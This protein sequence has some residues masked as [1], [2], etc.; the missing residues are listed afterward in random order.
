LLL[1][2][3]SSSAWQSEG[4]VNP[5]RSWLATQA[6]TKNTIR[7]ILVYAKR[8]GSVLDTAD[9]SPLLTLSP[10][11]K[12]HAMTALANLAKYQGRYG[13][14]LKIRQRYSLKWSSGNN[15]LQ[16]LERFFNPDLSLETMLQQI[17]KMIAC[18]PAFMSKIIKFAVL[19]GL[20][21]AEVVESVKLLNAKNI[22]QYFNPERQ[23]LEHFRFPEIFLRQT[24]KAYISF[25]TPEMLGIVKLAYTQTIP[26]YNAIRLTCQ[27]KGITCDMRFARKL[28]ASHL[29]HEGIQPEVV[30]LLQGRV[31]TSILT[32]HYLVPQSSLRDD[33]LNA[34]EK[35]ERQL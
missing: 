20:R 2:C 8:Y 30:D 32:R 33:V 21:P 25:V 7:E 6:K 4:F 10:R 29:R 26:S 31:S 3:P 17:K 28:F 35:L 11:N 34:L 5:L 15:T 23:A 19:T 14:F 18:T 27:R 24:K 13:Q 16:S 1:F 12:Q 22:P 9:A